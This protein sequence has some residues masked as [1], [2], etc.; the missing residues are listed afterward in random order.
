M[1]PWRS[2]IGRMR[3]ELLAPALDPAGRPERA[4]VPL[5]EGMAGED[6]VVEQP[7]VVD[8]AG[9][10]PHVV[11]LGG[12][13][14][15]LAGPGLQRVEDHHRPVDPLAEALEAVDQVEREAVGGP[16]RDADAR[17]EALVA[18]RVERV[19]HRLARVARAVRVV[20]Q[21][22]VERVGAAALEA[23]LGGHSDVVRVGLRAAQPRVGEAREPLR[24]LALALVEVVPDRAHQ[25]VV[26]ARDTGQR[27]PEQRVGLAG[28]VGVGRD[29]ACRSRRRASAARPAGRRPAARRSA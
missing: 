16:G 14:H 6:V 13:Q 15:Q 21:Q 1:S 11:A 27:A 20:E 25:R 17:G 7:A 22:Q 18:H 23:A 28:A 3:V 19:P 26:A 24:A 9:D 5:R 29:H 12:G 4:V 2:A 8:D 10:Q